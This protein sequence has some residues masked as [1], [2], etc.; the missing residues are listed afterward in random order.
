M[1]D[2]EIRQEY[3]GTVQSKSGRNPVE[4][5]SFGEQIRDQTAK[6]SLHKEPPNFSGYVDLV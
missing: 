6:R 2:E 5:D 3:P 1:Q 4:L